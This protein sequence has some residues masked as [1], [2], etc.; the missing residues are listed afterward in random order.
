M[1][2]RACSA[3]AGVGW[4]DPSKRS[5]RSGARRTSPPRLPGQCCKAERSVSRA[6]S[7]TAA[8]PGSAPQDADPAP[9]VGC[10]GQQERPEVVSPWGRRSVVTGLGLAQPALAAAGLATHPGW[11]AC[12]DG[13]PCVPG[14]R[15]PDSLHTPLP[16]GSKASRLSGPVPVSC[17]SDLQQC[18][19]HLSTA[20]VSHQENCRLEAVQG[21]CRGDAWQV[22]PDAADDLW[23]LEGTRVRMVLPLQCSHFLSCPSHPSLLP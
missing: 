7:A 5:P 17:W 12:W 8:Q 3:G 21:L 6:A 23:H 2:R 10:P 4:I 15:Q 1:C 22:L 19:D 18:P 13:G 20:L 9:R 11:E 16:T 14:V